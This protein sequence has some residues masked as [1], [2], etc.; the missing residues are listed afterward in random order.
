LHNQCELKNSKKW[1]RD[2]KMHRI[3]G[4][5]TFLAF[6]AFMSAISLTATAQQ[7]VT[8]SLAFY[9]QTSSITLPTG[10]SAATLK[11]VGTSSPVGI[12]EGKISPVTIY[13]DFP[14]NV[15]AADTT[16]NRYGVMYT[17]SGA[18][19]LN[20]PLNMRLYN[21]VTMPTSNAT[22]SNPGNF[23]N[24]L[25]GNALTTYQ[26]ELDFRQNVI[27][28]DQV[29]SYSTTISLTITPQ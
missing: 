17:S 16:P 8:V 24:L 4:I 11:Y 1:V 15:D 12:W 20:D 19:H 21:S 28:G 6:C 10:G 25:P 18:A 22:I 5:L 26:G 27:A 9:G 13:A 2:V 29:G 3:G 14:F 23:L 7:T